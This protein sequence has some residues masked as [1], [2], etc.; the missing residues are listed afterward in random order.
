MTRYDEEDFEFAKIDG[1]KA[2]LVSKSGAALLCTHDSWDKP[3]WIA[4]SQIGEDS[5][6]YRKGDVGILVVRKWLAVKENLI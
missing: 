5:E 4:Q 6:V 1:V 2:L 3:V